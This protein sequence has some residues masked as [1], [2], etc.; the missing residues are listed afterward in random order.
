MCCAY[1][2]T[3]HDAHRTE[4]NGRPLAMCP[5]ISHPTTNS[6]Q[7]TFVTSDSSTAQLNRLCLFFESESDFVAQD[8]I[9][10]IILLLASQVLGLQL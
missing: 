3:R 4:G 10:F 5:S 1:S 2:H 7:D 9:K 6:E 8:G